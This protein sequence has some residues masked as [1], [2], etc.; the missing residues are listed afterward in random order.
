[1]SSSLDNRQTHWTVLA[2]RWPSSDAE[3]SPSLSSECWG[4]KNDGIDDI[5]VSGRVDE[6]EAFDKDGTY[7]DR[8]EEDCVGATLS[9]LCVMLSFE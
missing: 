3:D 1:M 7:E 8:D 5:G 6:S 9:E 2:G 4:G